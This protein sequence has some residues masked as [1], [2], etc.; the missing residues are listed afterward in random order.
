MIA[1]IIS[2]GVASV[3]V[4]FLLNMKNSLGIAKHMEEC[5]DKL[6]NK[7]D[8]V[9]DSP[10]KEAQS[11]DACLQQKSDFLEKFAL[12]SNHKT[13]QALPANVP[14][15]Y[16]GVWR[17]SQPNCTYEHS[18][19]ADGKFTSKPIECSISSNEFYG[20]WN[21][22]QTKMVWFPS[23]GVVWPLD[24]NPMESVTPNA[25]VLVERNGSHTQFTKVA[26]LPSERCP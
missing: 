18:L 24:I 10:L 2:Y 26:A 12:R 20:E 11:M 22:Q 14:C 3:I 23:E 15:Q 13:L 5:F 19:N 25:F 17:A 6:A 7:N 9:E 16:V 21:V 8:K 1:R 4:L